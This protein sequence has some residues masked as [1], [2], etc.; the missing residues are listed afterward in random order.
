MREK[1][2]GLCRKYTDLSMEEIDYIRQ[3][4]LSL[5]FLADTEEAD[6]FINCP[7]SGG[8]SVVVA[9]AK[10]HNVS[11]AY[12]KYIIGMFARRA[13]EP[14]VD[15]S[16]RLG[17]TTKR[18]KALSQE[19][20]PVIQVVM[21]IR[22]K[23][24]TI[25]VLT[26][27]RLA[28]GREDDQPFHE[29]FGRGDKGVKCSAEKYEARANW[30]WVVDCIEEGMV[31]IDKKGFVVFRN[32]IARQLYKRLGYIEDILGQ[33]YRNISLD[34]M[35]MGREERVSEVQV[36]RYSLRIR[37]IPA[38]T[39]A[40]SFAVFVADVTHIKDQERELILKSVAVQEMHHRVKNNLQMIVSLIRLQVRRTKN[41]QA[42]ELLD[43]AAYRIQTIAMTHQLLARNGMDRVSLQDV[44]R[45]VVDNAV[46]ANNP[47]PRD[48]SV[49]VEG[50]DYKVNSDL[51]TTVALIV[52][53]LVHN[54]L[55]HAFAGRTKGT[56]RIWT[57]KETDL[58]GVVSVQDDGS[59][60][61]NGRPEH[62][63]LNI[64]KVLVKEKLRGSLNVSSGPKGTRTSFGFQM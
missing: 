6:V 3:I 60:F 64:V 48:I 24:K 12:R 52:N 2:E 17:C 33:E 54:S 29:L 28:D 32:E 19:N 61:D 59:G 50:K 1:I 27:E 37:K 5:P 31:L 47:E 26:Y 36:G 55:E 40:L 18:M 51:A 11:S 4:S 58:Y 39:R 45:N 44:L 13:N 38:P 43:E 16:L 15:R 46:Q 53:E 42:Y 9:Q 7:C 21:P 57:G 10:P 23:G 62:L 30:R 63:G 14:A 34:K 22:Y 20:V 41:P 56:I 35:D 25:G 49:S 8:D